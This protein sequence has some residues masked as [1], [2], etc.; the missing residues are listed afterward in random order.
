[1]SRLTYELS[2]MDGVVANLYAGNARVL[3]EVRALNRD[4]AEIAQ[5]IAEQLCP[6]DTLYMSEHI[7]TAFSEQGL[8]WSLG[9]NASDF[10]GVPHRR[11]GKPMI[12]YPPEVDQGNSQQSAQ[13]TLGPTMAAVEPD[14]KE[15]LRDIISRAYRKQV[16]G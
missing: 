9:W 12:F 2:N 16:A 8:A 7:R 10:V 3:R 15:R 1:M 4:T 14:Y 6:K 11:T 5:N 13:P